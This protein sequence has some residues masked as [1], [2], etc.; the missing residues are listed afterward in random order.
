M[1]EFGKFL[2]EIKQLKS[3]LKSFTKTI[4]DAGNDIKLSVERVRNLGCLEIYDKRIVFYPSK[5][6]KTFLPLR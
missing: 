3:C 2:N 6:I 5:A 1:N 4:H